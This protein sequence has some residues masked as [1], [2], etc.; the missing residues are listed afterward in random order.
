MI[1][2]PAIEEIIKSKFKVVVKN[3][4]RLQIVIAEKQT[5][6]IALFT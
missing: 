1:K 5:K 2:N 6:S 3:N 4:S